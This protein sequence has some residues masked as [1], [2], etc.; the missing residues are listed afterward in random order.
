MIENPGLLASGNAG[1]RATNTAV[2]IHYFPPSCVVS[3]SSIFNLLEYLL[4]YGFNIIW[5]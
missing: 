3:A 4:P 5:G 1:Y 2:R